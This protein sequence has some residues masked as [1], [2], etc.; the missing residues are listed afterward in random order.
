[1]LAVADLT[2][3]Q[4]GVPHLPGVGSTFARGALTTV[5]GRTGAGKTTL[6]RVIAGLVTPDTGTVTLDGRDWRRLPPWRRPVAMVTQQ[7]INFPHLSALD[8]VAFP[9]V[10]AGQPRDQARDKARAML[11]RV[12]R[13]AMVD[14]RPG[15][16][17]GGQQQ[18]V[19]IARA[20][21]KKAPVLLLDEPFVNLDYKLREGLREELVDLL[22]AE[23]QTIVIYVSTDPREALQMGDRIVLMAEGRVVQA[24]A[25]REVYGTPQ[26]LTAAQVVSDPPLNAL[27]LVVDGNGATLGV[28]G[29][30]DVR[31]LPPGS[32]TLGLRAQDITQGGALQANV[33]LSEV[34]GSETVTHLDC[35]GQPLVMLEKTVA[36][37]PLGAMLGLTLNLSRALVFDA[38][39]RRVGGGHG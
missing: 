18:R 24:G 4:S 32:Y 10:R 22:R 38:G 36:D 5:L 12:G 34:S 21:V 33:V 14:R 25:P 11:G 9:L 8:N 13:G 37:H 31:A 17:S 35:G 7:F 28:L 20:L 16:L 6:M 3:T 15:A 19:A 30:Q 27:P 26:T 39:G 29:R 23:T 1:M 2:L